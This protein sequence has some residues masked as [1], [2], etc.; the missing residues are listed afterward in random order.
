MRQID[1]C[2]V[3]DCA[4]LKHTIDASTNSYY[5]SQ[6]TV[7]IFPLSRP[8]VVRF[9]NSLSQTNA[10]VIHALVRPWHLNADSFAIDMAVSQLAARRK[11]SMASSFVSTVS[12]TFNTSFPKLVILS[13][14]YGQE[15]CPYEKQLRMTHCGKRKL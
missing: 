4:N 2:W 5:C 10:A 7:C 11:E 8:I 13:D 15:A 3:S 9:I 14:I 12:K 6:R 1:K